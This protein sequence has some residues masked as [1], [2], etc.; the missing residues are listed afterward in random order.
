MFQTK[1]I[2]FEGRHKMLLVLKLFEGH[3][4]VIINF[5]NGIL[6]IFHCQDHDLDNIYWINLLNNIC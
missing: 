4:K 1:V 5:L 2:W 3:V 6:Y